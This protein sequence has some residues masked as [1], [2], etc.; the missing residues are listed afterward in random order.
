MTEL[1]LG[2]LT[3]LGNYSYLIV[4][5]LVFAESGLL[6]LLPGETVL[7]LA[8]V[9]ASRHI[10]AIVPLIAVGCVA[11]ALGDASGY[12]LG[13]GPA[14]RRF[15]EKGH[16]LVMQANNTDR[17]VRLLHK[18]G[19]GAIVVSRFVGLLRVATPFVCGLTDMPPRRFFPVSIP[20][21]L[22]WGAVVA[23]AGYLGG[24][25]YQK[26]HHWIGRGSLALGILILI[27][28]LIWDRQRRNGSGI[29]AQSSHAPPP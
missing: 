5:A 3:H 25:A 28:V 4:F 29:D 7:L 15:H 11:A 9:L 21:C 10:L 12:F 16:F 20:T 22:L 18:H 6:L 13:R 19:A 23:S 2:W 27:G 24:S 8:G 17:V 14:R 1:L 26:F